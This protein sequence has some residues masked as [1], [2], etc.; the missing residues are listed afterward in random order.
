[1][2]EDVNIHK[3]F[4]IVVWLMIAN[5][6]GLHIKQEIVKWLLGVVYHLSQCVEK[7]NYYSKDIEEIKI[8]NDDVILQSLRFRKAYGGMNGDMNMI[9]YY[10]HYLNNE[11]INVNNDKIPIIRLDIESLN[12]N[13]WIIE[14][15]DFHCNR[16]I[17]EHVS[18]Q[19][20]EYNK[21]HIKNLIWIFSSSKNK[22]VVGLD[23]DS[24]LDKD[25]IKISNVVKTYQRNCEFY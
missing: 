16:Y 20:K 14:A 13:E 12:K 22:R 9:E 5:T 15:N 19:F 17:L 24:N 4:P 3:C 11:G 1:M 18:R 23:I 2:L 8:D 7:T 10:I 6:K 21:G 25:W